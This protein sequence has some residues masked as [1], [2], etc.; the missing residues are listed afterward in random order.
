MF[1][2]YEPP[3]SL[4][5]N[6]RDILKDTSLTYFPI[7]HFNKDNSLYVNKEIYNEKGGCFLD[8]SE[9]KIKRPN[10]LIFDLIKTN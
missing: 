1:W 7:R 4:G 2:C 10:S 6:W 5:K 3:F 9:I 8:M